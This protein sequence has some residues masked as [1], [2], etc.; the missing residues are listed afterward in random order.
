MKAVCKWFNSSKGFGFLT[1][2]EGG[3][4]IF[5]HYSAI[6]GDGYRT[7]EEGQRVLCDVVK[8]S[9]GLSAERV[10]VLR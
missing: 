5:C 2:E 9:K 4:D 7:L 1:P 3:E 8:G 6:E 10:R